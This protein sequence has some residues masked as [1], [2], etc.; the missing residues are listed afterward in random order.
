MFSKDKK[1]KRKKIV[2]RMGVLLVFIFAITF[3]VNKYGKSSLEAYGKNSNIDEIEI[4]SI[5]EDGDSRIAV[6]YP[7][8]QNENINVVVKK[9][10][11]ESLESF[12]KEAENNQLSEKDELYIDF[13]VYRYSED[14]VSFKFNKYIYHPGRAHGLGLIHT[15]TFN[16]NDGRLYSLDDIFDTGEY[17][18][19]LSKKTYSELSKLNV[20]KQNS[21]ETELLKKGTLPT[22][23]NFDKF[24]LDKNELVLFFDPY[25]VGSKSNAVDSLKIPLTYFDNTLKDYISKY[26]QTVNENE[27]NQNESEI[28]GESVET[29]VEVGTEEN[30]IIPEK[31]TSTQEDLLVGIEHLR[32]EKLV[33]I[34]FDDGPHKTLTPALLDILKNEDVKATFYV[35][36][37][38]VE[39]YPDILKRAAE[40]GHQIGS[41][42]Y[43]HKNLPTL[44]E[45]DRNAE[46]VEASNIIEQVIGKKPST[47][48]PPYGSINES[49]KVN[50]DTPLILWSVDPL[51][52]KHRNADI[53]YEN[54]VNA[55]S[56]GDIIL[57]HD[58]HATS[59][60]A[61]SRIIPK[62][63]A[64]G[65]TFVTV[66]QLILLRSEIVNGNVYTAIRQ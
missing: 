31:N 11:K 25:Q 56:D 52:W 40:E 47:M 10:I 59:V 12:E 50:S 48:R 33:A 23:E 21:N 57:L 38:R 53:V 27:Q 9:Y 20:Y 8:A 36:G 49:M 43:N 46:I 32:N 2:L 51:D 42:T 28:N 65:Y 41:H 3:V 19:I 55:V 35:L 7:V 39:Y 15:M 6:H 44:S 4:D 34:T 1:V 17:L 62:L 54:V 64:E 30:I 26:L 60:E 58:I 63:K 5:I 14:I 24:V 66:D 45:I 13:D 16:L 22:N 61:V 18:N 29:N 37:S